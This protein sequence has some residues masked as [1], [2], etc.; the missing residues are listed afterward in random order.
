MGLLGILVLLSLIGI[1]Y[2]TPET[3]DFDLYHPYRHIYLVK[4]TLLGG[5]NF[6]NKLK[7]GFSKYLV[8]LDCRKGLIWFQYTFGTASTMTEIDVI[9]TSTIHGQVNMASMV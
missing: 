1:S 5:G 3:T 2:G 6:V 7:P 9:D 8:M 4:N